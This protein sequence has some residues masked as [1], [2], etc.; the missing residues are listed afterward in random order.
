MRK[1]SEVFY[2]EN[3]NNFSDFSEYQTSQ[4]KNI[5]KKSRNNITICLTSSR[6]KVVVQY[7]C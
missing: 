4:K 3:P 5:N 6:G 7:N 1:F 2:M